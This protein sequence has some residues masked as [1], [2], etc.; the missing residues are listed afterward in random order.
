M[1]SR[2]SKLRFRRRLRLRQKQVEQFG[3]TAEDQ[4]ERNFFK[5]LERLTNVRRFVVTWLLL[6]VLLA[7][8]V[9][10]QIR[11]LGA[12]YQMP[13]PVPGGT[14]T[15]GIL[16]S[17]TNANPL[18]A[19]SQ[20]DLA[21]SKLLFAGLFTY[22]QA[23]NLKGDLAESIK[24]DD[25]G[26][27]YT[28]T[29]KPNLRW[30]DGKPLTAEDVAFTYNVIENPDAQSP[31]LSSWQ[32]IQVKAVDKRTILFTLPSQL[33][34]FPYSLTNG[35]VPKHILGQYSVRSLRSLQ[36]NT[37][38]PVGAGPFSLNALEVTGTDA[39]NREERIAFT[40]F[41]DYNGGKPK[42]DRLVIHSFRD[43]DQ[44]LSSYRM[45]DINAMVGLTKV[46][47]QIAADASSR[48]YNIPLTAAAMTFFRTTSP[49]LSDKT[50][51]QA[52]VRA[53]DTKRIIDNL[54]YPTLPVREPILQSQVGYNAA[55][56]QFGF[57]LAAA[58]SQLQ[59]AGW[60]PGSDG[61][62][63][64]D[65]KALSFNL[66][67]QDNSEYATV[68]KELSKQWR[69]AGVDAK[70]SLKSSTD[71]QVTLSSHDYDALLYGISIGKD[72]DV[73]VYWD[74]K[75]ADVRSAGR[76]NFSEYKSGAADAALQSGRTRTDPTLRMIKY[77]PFL[78]AWRDDAPAVG[79]YQPRFLYISHSKVYGLSEH[80][81]NAETERYTN[82]QNWMVRETNVSQAKR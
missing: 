30:Q 18:Y 50:V 57:D 68:A 1:V 12:Y 48:I 25:R 74:S 78:Q 9:T 55:Y 8:C 76:L 61:I 44:M 52:L 49:I 46:P 33:S 26:I 53:T 23:N 51:R 32:G 71:F 35:I 45:R 10:A 81:I 22:D 69:R 63:R 70:V 34:S 56:G 20:V 28:V 43:Q 66:Y 5:R 62:R 38:K 58:Q 40:P 73:Y 21:V 75:N 59:Q 4:L 16:G 77:Q 29:L 15:E 14:Y 31:F 27:V 80:A 19:T 64:K 42:L 7:G 54:D 82:V 39:T 24:S 67:A 65:G 13:A 72:P 79:L 60:V 41:A 3:I 6:L 37:S 2:A 17:F 47:D 11:S 36:F